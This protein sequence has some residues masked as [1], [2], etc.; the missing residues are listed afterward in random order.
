M[1]SKISKIL[2]ILGLAVIIYVGF[3]LYKME[4]TQK[5]LLETCQN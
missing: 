1:R 2:M 3:N 5:S 4:V